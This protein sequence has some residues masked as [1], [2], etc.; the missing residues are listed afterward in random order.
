MGRAVNEAKITTRSARSNLKARKAPYWRAIDGGLH[1]G[2]RKGM[3]AGTWTVRYRNPDRS[4][5]TKAIGKADDLLNADGDEVLD[6]S[7]AQN[8]A[9]E[10]HQDHIA[11]RIASP[12]TAG[13]ALDDYF[14][15]YSL[16]GRGAYQVKRRIK[17]DIKPVFNN[18]PVCDL[19]TRQIRQWHEKMAARPAYSRTAKGMLGKGESRKLDP[20]A[21]RKRQATANRCLTIL[22]AALNR[23]FHDGKAESDDPWRRVKP[24]RNVDAARIRYIT[25]D[26][27]TRLINTCETDFRDLVKAA[28]FTGCRYGELITMEV[29]D[30]NP[31]SKMLLV[32]ITKNGKPRHVALT[33]DG[34]SLYN[35]LT[36][37]RSGQDQMFLRSDGDPWGKSHQRRRLR[38]A[39]KR[40]K[41]DPPISFHILRHS[42][43]SWLAMNGVP[44]R[45]IADALGHAD[46]RITEKYYAHMSPS[47]VADTVR[48]NLPSLGVSESTNIIPMAESN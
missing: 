5:V 21:I 37:G 33:D 8:K 41:I 2:Y 15:S 30:F 39:S 31:D 48:A 38:D 18:V 26:E 40:A 28:L 43:G 3:D 1:I 45:V 14:A 7:Q 44:I 34:V 11:E 29:S 20:D 16:R 12:Y 35:G 17:V 9:R 13:D 24:F 32:R 10:W 25:T 6:F 47:Y 36:V 46:T 23:A 4:Y 42:Y 27:A 19:T 22:K